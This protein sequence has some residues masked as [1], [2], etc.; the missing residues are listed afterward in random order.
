MAGVN[1][2]FIPFLAFITGCSGLQMQSGG[3]SISIKQIEDLNLGT[4]ANKVERVLGR[5]S[6]IRDVDSEV[7]WFYR[8]QDKFKYQRAA[9]F[10]DPHSKLLKSK[11]IIPIE[12]E[13]EFNINNLFKSKFIRS[14]FVEIRQPVCNGHY[15]SG[16]YFL[17]DEKDGVVIRYRKKIEDVEAISWSF[18]DETKKFAQEIKRKCFNKK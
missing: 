9:V 10:L 6:E 18:P 16:E 13:Q 17:I 14:N 8:N 1:W 11:L 15:I 12:G 3:Q 5:P 7:A 4:P 2:Y